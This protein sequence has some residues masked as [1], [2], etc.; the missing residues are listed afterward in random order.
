MQNR[1]SSKEQ[2]RPRAV[3]G[4][5]VA[6]SHLWA[7]WTFAVAQPILDLIGRQPDFLVAQRLTGA[8][9][10][11]VL[12]IG[13]TLGIPVLLAS[14]LVIPG[15]RSSRAGRLWIDGVRTLLAGAFVLQLLHRLPAV[16]ALVLAVAGGTAMVI[17]PE[18]V[19]R[20]L[21]CSGHWRRRSG[22]RTTRLPAST[23]CSR[24]T[25]AGRG[26][27]LRARLPDR[28]SACSAD[29]PADRADG[30]R[31]TADEL[32]STS[33]RLHRQPAVPLIRRSG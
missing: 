17:L 2:D 23:R 12:A 5:W 15:A 31:R 28:R 3:S 26:D 16:V 11:A 9:L 13:T 10:L 27:S 7:L 20:L 19:P 30:L 14:P 21:D 18:P 24:A 8:P 22:R 32:A 4:H 6:A 25:A 33:R 29:R 1:A